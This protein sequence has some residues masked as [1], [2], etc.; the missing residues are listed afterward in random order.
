M[1]EEANAANG[2]KT[3]ERPLRRESQSENAVLLLPQSHSI[4]SVRPFSANGNKRSFFP[5]MG[6]HF[7][8]PEAL[9][10]PRAEGEGSEKNQMSST[11]PTRRNILT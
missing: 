2:V 10:A 11:R 7:R 9:P 3:P 1:T 4:I 8:L 5:P 6:T